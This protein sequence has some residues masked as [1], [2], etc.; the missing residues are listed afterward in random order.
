MC[1]ILVATSIAFPAHIAILVL[2]VIALA[3]A[4]SDMRA[5][6]QLHVAQNNFGVEGTR[7]FCDNLGLSAR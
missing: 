4:I 3:N 6:L 2:G 7:F 5:L 1:F